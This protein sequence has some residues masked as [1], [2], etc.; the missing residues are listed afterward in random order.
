MRGVGGAV[1]RHAVKTLGRP[2]GGRVERRQFAVVAVDD[3]KLRWRALPL[4]AGSL[5]IR[6]VNVVSQA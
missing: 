2:G 1:V 6:L 5:G 3:V 4:S